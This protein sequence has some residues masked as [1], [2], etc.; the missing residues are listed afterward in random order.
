MALRTRLDTED[1]S[2]P[3]KVSA[4]NRTSEGIRLLVR[5]DLD[6]LEVVVRTSRDGVLAN[7][8]G[9]RLGPGLSATGRL[10]LLVRRGAPSVFGLHTDDDRLVYPHME[11]GRI[12]AKQLI[13]AAAEFDELSG[14]DRW[15]ATAFIR[16]L[17]PSI[18]G[19]PEQERFSRVYK[20]LLD[21]KT[22]KRNI[23]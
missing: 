12:T 21:P 16:H 17:L 15:S 19:T 20:E 6:S 3:L 22:E 8:N 4:E 2:Q 7:Q 1:R 5:A 23:A 9:I 18:N 11:D 13:I 14:N 10:P